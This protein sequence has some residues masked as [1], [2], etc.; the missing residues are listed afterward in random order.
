M[1]DLRTAP[2]AT[3]AEWVVQG[4]RGF[5]A[6]VL[7]VVPDGFEMY[8][9][10]F[11]PAWREENG[12][13]IAV[14]WHDV[15]ARNGRV[16]HRGMQWQHLVG[17]YDGHTVRQPGLW[18]GDPMEGDLPD[19]IAAVLAAVLGEHTA[20]PDRCWFGFWEGWGCEEIQEI[21]APM[22]EIPHRRMLLWTGPVTAIATSLGGQSAN[23]WW[24][25]DRAWC[26]ATE[27]DFMSTY[28]GG[29]RA[30]IEALVSHPDLE[31]AV[32]APTDGITWASDHLN[33]PPD[34]A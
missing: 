34:T 13:D 12:Q 26:V 1:G 25:G 27:I 22:F 2:D 15:A 17:A 32:V 14:R 4:M 31:A 10:I 24:P 29:A 8:A 30:C 11:H 20:T 6:S 5:A 9:R 23:L 16:A 18:D 7:S 19:G 28:V 21:P 3:P 33:P